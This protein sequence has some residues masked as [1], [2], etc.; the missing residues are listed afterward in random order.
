MRNDDSGSDID[1]GPTQQE[2][3]LLQES[4]YDAIPDVSHSKIKASEAL[5]LMLDNSNLNPDG[6]KTLKGVNAF[7]MA[8]SQ[9]PV[10]NLLS[11]TFGTEQ[12]GSAKENG[13]PWNLTCSPENLALDQE[14]ISLERN[15]ENEIEG[16]SKLELI[17]ANLSNDRD[18][19]ETN[20]ENEVHF[21]LDK[22]S[23]S[24]SLQ[25]SVVD[26]E[27][28]DK[29]D[30][31]NLIYEDSDVEGNA[32]LVEGDENSSNHVD[33][34]M[35]EEVEEETLENFQ[36]PWKRIMKQTQTVVKSNPAHKLIETEAEVEEDE[37]MNEGGLE[38]E[39]QSIPNEYD[40]AMLN[41]NIQEPMN[42]KA[43]M[44]LH[45]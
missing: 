37:F 3:F 41:D 12:D 11:G 26:D 23:H 35:E 2:P 24:G 9:E 43:V 7:M 19:L 42:E 28:P 6:F 14:E 15:N 4:G 31:Q 45:Q 20:Q 1:F 29:I 22:Q 34:E 38:G 32:S 17:V 13:I 10:L 18:I 39:D 8:E 16:E 40:K 21:D 36:I 5:D 27:V 25:S 30:I 44:E 33:E